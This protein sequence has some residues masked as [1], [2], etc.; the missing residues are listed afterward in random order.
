MRRQSIKL[1]EVMPV[2]KAK[3][4]YWRAVCEETRKHGSERGGQKE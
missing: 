1:T 2:E 4:R 3:R